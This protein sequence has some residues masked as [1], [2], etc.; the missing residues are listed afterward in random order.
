[1]V[2]D[3]RRGPRNPAARKWWAAKR[4]YAEKG[5]PADQWMAI[6]NRECA[7]CGG[8][9]PERKVYCASCLD[10]QRK[11]TWSKYK[12]KRRKTNIKFA[13]NCRIGSAIRNSCVRGSKGG[14]KTFDLLSYTA[15]QL[16]ERLQHTMPDGYAW[17]D[18]LEGKLHVDHIRPIASFDFEMPEDSDFG[19][20][21]ALSNLQ[22]L[23]AAE[24]IKKGDSLLWAPA[25]P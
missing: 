18:F 25:V 2:D 14:R 13:L 4:E 22:L 15:S 21:W 10:A 9:R 12:S 6:R 8:P 17:H 20:C 11:Q 5:L 24:N 1:M 19:K 23:P 3:K 16:V 7:S